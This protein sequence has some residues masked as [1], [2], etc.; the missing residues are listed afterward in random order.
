M[1][2]S[3][4]VQRNEIQF[5]ERVK[6]LPW[7]K[8]HKTIIFICRFSPSKASS[9]FSASASVS[10]SAMFRRSESFSDFTFNFE[11][12]FGCHWVAIYRWRCYND[13]DC[14]GKAAAEV[15]EDETTEGGNGESSRDG[16]GGRILESGVW[17]YWIRKG[18][19]VTNAVL[20]WNW[21]T[22]FI[23]NIWI[24][25][26]STQMHLRARTV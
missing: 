14:N 6:R 8:I 12:W 9:F 26:R 21:K 13:G 18:V 16:S 19:Y 23:G 15:V 24:V 1:I 10:T 17:V 11:V 4:R 5:I 22:M 25:W 20:S 7:E 2:D 3:I